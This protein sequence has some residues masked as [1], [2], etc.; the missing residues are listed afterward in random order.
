MNSDYMGSDAESCGEAY[1]EGDWARAVSVSP[2]EDSC[3]TF[4]NAAQRPR[5]M[6]CPSLLIGSRVTALTLTAVFFPTVSPEAMTI[7]VGC[8]PTPCNPH[9]CDLKARFWQCSSTGFVLKK[10]AT[11]SAGSE[12]RDS[13]LVW[14]KPL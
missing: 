12:C 10:H 9:I 6:L 4:V 3:L 2:P 1:K 5:V 11:A 13:S 8:G 14:S 7:L